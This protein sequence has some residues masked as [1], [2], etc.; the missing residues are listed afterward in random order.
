VKTGQ[1]ANKPDG[2]ESFSDN[3]SSQLKN[4]TKTAREGNFQKAI[5]LAEQIPSKSSVYQQALNEIAQWQGQQRQHHIKQQAETQARKLLA[6]ARDVANRGGETDMKTAIRIAEEAIA[7]VSPDNNISR[8]AHNVIA[9]W[10]Q[11][12]TAKREQE[13][14]E[15]AYKCS[16]QSSEPDAQEGVVFTESENDLTGSNCSITEAPEAPAMGAWVCNK[17]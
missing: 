11:E 9:Q 2:S 13:A 7:Q 1:S 17:K 16:C 6:K 5:A 14:V 8:E 3:G 10:Q 4:A 12:A 15:S